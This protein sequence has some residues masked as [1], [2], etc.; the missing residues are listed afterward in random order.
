MKKIWLIPLILIALVGIVSGANVE[1]ITSAD[2]LTEGATAG[3]MVTAIFSWDTGGTEGTNNCTAVN[4]SISDGT[5]YIP[6]LNTSTAAFGFNNTLVNVSMN[7][8]G[9]SDDLGSTGYTITAVC[10]NSTNGTILGGSTTLIGTDTEIVGI[11]NTNPICTHVNLASNTNFDITNSSYTISITGTNGSSSTINFGSN[12]YTTTEASDVFS[13]DIGR[14]PATGH[15]VTATVSDG[16][17][18][19]SCATLNGVNLK[20]ASNGGKSVRIPDT[21]VYIVDGKAVKGTG[22]LKSLID[23]FMSLF[24]R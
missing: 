17:N 2:Y 21:G 19:T 22:W 16:R 13:Y 4:W 20:V 12:A 18:T 3:A 11:D 8:T 9:L 23:W 6:T 10:R 24:R 15:I 7:T 1:T 5:R 14:V